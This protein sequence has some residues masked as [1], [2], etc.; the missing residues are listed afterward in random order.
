MIK[1]IKN[2]FAK[3]EDRTTE[4]SV[5]FVMGDQLLSGINPE[6]ATLADYD[7]MRYDDQVSVCLE[8]RI[9]GMIAKGWSIVAPEG[10]EDLADEIKANL[11]NL[12]GSF[13]DT[14][15]QIEVSRKVFGFSVSE[16]LWKYEDGKLKIAGIKTRD[17]QK[18]KFY[19]DKYGDL[20]EDGLKQEVEAGEVAL[21]VEKFIIHVNRMENSNYYGVSEF[22]AA[23]AAWK[24]KERIRN[25]YNVLLE[26][27][28]IP[29][30]IAKYN[31]AELA[32]LT[33]AQRKAEL[34]KTADVLKKTHQGG[35][36][37]VPD[38]YQSEVIKLDGSSGEAFEKALDR[39]DFAISK[40]L[41]VPSELG[42][43]NVKVGSNAKASTQYDIFM[44]V[45]NKD[46]ASLEETINEQLIK[47]YVFYNYGPQDEYPK[48]KF[49]PTDQEDVEK[50]VKLYNDSLKSGAIRP[51]KEGEA[52]TLELLNY[53]EVNEEGL[54]DTK[55]QPE[56]KEPKE[57]VQKDNIE[58]DKE[59]FSKKS[60]NGWELNSFEQKV[61]FS[62]IDNLFEAQEN[63]LIADIVDII[64]EIGVDMTNKI[65]N[66]N[67]LSGK[68]IEEI[69]NLLIK[70]SYI[71]NLKTVFQKNLKQMANEGKQSILEEL[72]P[73]K[74]AIAKNE[75][76]ESEY[77][78]Y[79]LT[80]SKELA[81]ELAGTYLTQTKKVLLVAIR[82]GWSEQ[83]TIQALN[84]VYS[85]A[86]E[87]GSIVAPAITEGR[88][89]TIVRTNLNAAFNKARHIQVVQLNDQTKDV[90][91][92]QFSEIL[93][94]RN[95]PFSVFINGKSVKVG[96]ELDQR[97]Q[98]P[99]HYNDRGVAVYINGTIEGEPDNILTSMP[100]LASYSGLLIS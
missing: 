5:A 59:E 11:N 58:E 6:D 63:K 32:N 41:K 84:E 99:L 31:A 28:G 97:L 4:H 51:T 44:M 43:L 40:A 54:L 7:T 24:Y 9:L 17:S 33:S 21:P 52:K 67:I 86:K 65:I 90:Y 88:L 30:V 22:K 78:T 48:F 26:R 2:F 10:K 75:L 53:P 94:D 69:N 71:G 74:F 70:G 77:Y 20:L 39:Y 13:Q 38:V 76:L 18:I 91:Y 45:I 34:K 98:Y 47:P 27:F 68:K 80:L 82:D 14:L 61:N 42:F 37:M 83:K 55:P 89:R 29:P 96:S 100:N 35:I 36:I 23:Y 95:H 25:L 81:G 12:K 56:E 49:N 15:E 66:K 62:K 60:Y 3:K 85:T 72:Q 8:V 73:I 19:P 57:P 1:Q 87:V 92:K 46:K 16:I 79:I 50:I 93:D 64:D